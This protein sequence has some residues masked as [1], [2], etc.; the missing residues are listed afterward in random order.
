[1]EAVVDQGLAVG[2]GVPA[3]EGL[4][5]GLA[6]A[7]DAEVDVARCPATGRRALAGLEVVDRDRAAERH[8]EMRV[9]VD[10]ARQHVLSRR[11]DRPLGRDVEIGADQQN[12][13]ALDEDVRDEVVGGGDDAPSPDQDRHRSGV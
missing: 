13:L 8:V 5:E 4:G 7:L 3:L 12:P 11:V 6:L 1:M 10:A 9:W 2:L